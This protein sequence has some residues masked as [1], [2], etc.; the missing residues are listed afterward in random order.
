MTTIHSPSTSASIDETRIIEP[1]LHH[2]NIA[3]T[4]FDEMIAWYELTIGMRVIHR[5]ELPAVRGVWM[6]NDR[7]NHRLAIIERD[8]LTA[9]PDKASHAGLRHTAFEYASIDDLL[10][11]YVRLR[12]HGIVPD[13]CLDHG[14]TI[15]FYYKDPDGNHLELQVDCFDDW[16]ESTA[17]VEHD[18]R[19]EKDPIGPRIDPNA[20]LA[21]RRAGA[22]LSELH[23]QGYTGG[24]PV[25]DQE[26]A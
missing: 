16:D 5:A 2:V 11:T 26:E 22:T 19:F 1:A 17:F 9:D 24:F 23:E 18:P 25:N 7:A 3:T 8:T 6:S 21:A 10:G 12:A 15:S 14:P 4:R 13:Y 20:M